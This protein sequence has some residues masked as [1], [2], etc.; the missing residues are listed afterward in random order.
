M[1]NHYEELNQKVTEI[2]E[3]LKD[4]GENVKSTGFE[5][6]GMDDE[7]GI[8]VLYQASKVEIDDDNTPRKSA[9]ERII[10]AGSGNVI[11]GLLGTLAVQSDIIWKMF[12]YVNSHKD[13][14]VE[15]SNT[16][17]QNSRDLEEM[18]LDNSK[19]L[20]KDD[21]EP[22]SIKAN[23]IEDLISQLEKLGLDRDDIEKRINA[24]FRKEY[25]RI[26]GVYPPAD[27]DVLELERRVNE[28]KKKENNRNDG[29]TN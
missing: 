2:Q 26:V 15:L 17:R 29:N 12:K 14:F 3:I 8:V 10:S 21:E 9:S 27:L 24:L 16:K 5:K 1:R 18:R 13:Q 11:L 25:K 6:A 22:I 28:M 7:F 20:A 19:S 23:S 4:L